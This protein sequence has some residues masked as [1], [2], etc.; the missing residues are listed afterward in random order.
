[1]NSA[2][3][4]KCTTSINNIVGYTY[5]VKRFGEMPYSLVWKGRWYYHLDACCYSLCYSRSSLP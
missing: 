5:S 4:K 3:A 2:F 1:M